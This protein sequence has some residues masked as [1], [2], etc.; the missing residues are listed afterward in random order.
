[1]L[2]FGGSVRTREVGD[3][4]PYLQYQARAADLFLA[5]RFV[6]TGR[7]GEADTFWGLELAGVWGPLSFQSEY[8]Q[9][10][11][12]LP[13]GALTNDDRSFSA[14]TSQ[15]TIFLGSPRIGRSLL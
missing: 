9:L 8:G 6:T 4:Q 1:V 2:H 5:N 7:I 15:F 14:A 10:D 13:G 3:D 12:D 11:V